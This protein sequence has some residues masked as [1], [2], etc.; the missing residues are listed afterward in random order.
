MTKRGLNGLF[1]RPS[2]INDVWIL[3]QW[4]L[5]GDWDLVIG[6]LGAVVAD[7]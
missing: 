5:F 2:D 6:I 4:D 7:D 1:T 3:G